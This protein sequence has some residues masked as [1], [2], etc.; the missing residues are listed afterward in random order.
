MT[1]E[2]IIHS[3]VDSRRFGKRIYRALVLDEATARRACAFAAEQPVDLMIARSP[4][5]RLVQVLEAGGFFLTDTHVTYRGLTG[6]FT[7][8]PAPP[9]TEIRQYSAADATE[10]EAIARAC[11]TDYDGH[12]HADP[13]LDKAACTEGY[14][15]LC[16]SATRDPR[17][18]VLV[19]VSDGRLSGFLTGRRTSAEVGEIM[20]NG[21]RPADQR[22]GI[23]TGLFRTVGCLLRGEGAQ[24]LVAATNL[25]NLAA[26]KVWVRHGLEPHSVLYTLHGWFDRLLAPEQGWGVP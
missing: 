16:L 21:V 10:L 22:R 3:E 1:A 7:S 24:A 11:F 12:Y 18:R 17:A 5:A 2:S 8:P 20:L 6:G 14:V 25:A 13:R 9:G 26:Q 4:T 19:S 15:E 23:Y